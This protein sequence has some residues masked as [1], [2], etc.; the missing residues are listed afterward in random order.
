MKTSLIRALFVG[1]VA[2]GAQSA[3]AGGMVAVT[4]AP[5]HSLVSM[6]TKGVSE[7]ALIVRPGASPHS[8]ALKPSEAS[9][10]DRAE[11]VFWMGEALEPWMAKAIDTLAADAMV[12]D[13]AMV[14]GVR[15]L[16]VRAE[17]IWATGDHQKSDPD[18]DITHDA[19][20]APD[21][22]KHRAYRRGGQAFDPHVWLD[23]ENAKAWLRVIPGILAMT[24]PD[25]ADTY[26]TNGRLA[27]ER[28]EA[29]TRALRE[30]LAPVRSIPYVVFH[31][32]YQYFETRF[33]LSPVATI[34]RSDADRPSAARIALIRDRLRQGDVACVFAEPQFE[35][36]LIDAVIAGS[37]IRKGILDP[38][39]ADLQPGPELYPTLMRR[40]AGAL[41]DCLD[42]PKSRMPSQ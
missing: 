35:P 29:L 23:P 13:L 42:S 18:R 10:L 9:A 6:V 22:G 25:H 30:Q 33:G 21:N 27:V 5:V 4:V 26:R 3:T 31:D 34:R 19:D 40:M 28:I 36:G 17:A 1:L 11:V 32:A 20:I 38:I 12:V 15:L 37:G 2:L 7:P 41:V 24:D 16:K 39:G 14:E 8:H